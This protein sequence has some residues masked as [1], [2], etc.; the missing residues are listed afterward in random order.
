MTAGGGDF[1]GALNVFLPLDLTKI[2][3]VC[4][5]RLPQRVRVRRQRGLRVKVVQQDDHVGQRTDGVDS[6]IADDGRLAGIRFGDDQEGP[7]VRPRLDR[8]RQNTRH[9]ADGPVQRQFADE[10]PF[11]DPLAPH[12]SCC[13]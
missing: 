8:H 3:I 13:R 11:A 9:R 2:H 4:T 10:H 5:L 7:L 1:E 6:D 12:L